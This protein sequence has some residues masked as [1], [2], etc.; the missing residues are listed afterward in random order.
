LTQSVSAPIW[1]LWQ[2]SSVSAR[3]RPCIWPQSACTV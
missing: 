3:A 1:F 2:T